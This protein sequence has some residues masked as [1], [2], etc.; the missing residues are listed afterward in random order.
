MTSYV[1][2]EMLRAMVSSLRSLEQR[3]GGI[4]VMGAKPVRDQWP[5]GIQATFTHPSWPKPRTFEFSIPAD[6]LSFWEEGESAT[7]VAEVAEWLASLTVNDMDEWMAL[8]D[9]C[10]PFTQEVET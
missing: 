7:P 3:G 8:G 6:L 2:S 9:D 5:L 1:A 4:R 10:A